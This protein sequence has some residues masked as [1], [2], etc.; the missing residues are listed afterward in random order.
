MLH[1][2]PSMHS[3]LF[4]VRIRSIFKVHNMYLTHNF[5]LSSNRFNW[6]NRDIVSNAEQ[7]IAIQNIVNDTSFPAPYILF[8]PPGTGKTSTL[9]EAI[10]QIYKLKP[11]AH[12]LVTA[13]TNFACNELAT[14]LLRYVPKEDIFRFFSRTFAKNITGLDIDLLSCSNLDN[15]DYRIPFYNEISGSRIFICTVTT[16]GRLALGGIKPDFFEYIFID[17]CGSAKEVASLIPIAGLGVTNE[18]ITAKIILAGD[19]KQLG[20]VVYASMAE[21]MGQKCS[22]L[23]R[24]MNNQIYQKDPLTRK[25]NNQLITKLLQ[26]YRSH[27]AILQ[28]SNE[29]FYEGELKAC[30]D[31]AIT[32][33][34]LNWSKLPNKEFPIIF[35]CVF[36]KMKR[37]RQS[38]SLFNRDELYIVKLYLEA[39][40]EGGING[41]MVTESDVGVI[42]P[43]A[44]QVQSI[45]GMCS[46]KG[47]NNISIGTTEQFQGREKKIII[48]ST[49]RSKAK[50]VGFLSNEKRLNVAIT[51]AKSLL[52][53]IGNAKTLMK[54]DDWRNFIEY[55]LN[56]GA[57]RGVPINGDENKGANDVGDLKILNDEI[58]S[59]SL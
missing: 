8:G 19:P 12:I 44:K 14:R 46:N 25:Y 36:G 5:F 15:G 7:I 43:Y 3:K 11:N 38:C 34:A 39:L 58:S 31:V 1:F 27:E 37:D 6:H 35:H 4:T 21:K 59:I 2:G 26:N 51:R 30:A 45:K 18:K 42:S 20:P 54:D 22:M 53:V 41:T 48:I 29:N 33:W 56:N 28:F 57:I 55:C 9:V 10:C 50:T 47:W 17:E 52:V 24:L 40:F 32:D 23:E 49:V 16:S 13:E